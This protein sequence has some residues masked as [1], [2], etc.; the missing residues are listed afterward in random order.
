MIT[1]YV[2]SDKNYILN[3]IKYFVTKMTSLVSVCLGAKN[4]KPCNIFKDNEKDRVNIEFLYNYVKDISTTLK[5]ASEIIEE[6]KLYIIAMAIKYNKVDVLKAFYDINYI[7]KFELL[8]ADNI[9]YDEG[10]REMFTESE[11]TYVR[12]DKDILLTRH[13]DDHIME[14]N[15]DALTL[16][17]IFE[18]YDVIDYLVDELK[19]YGKVSEDETY[20][21]CPILSM[22]INYKVETSNKNYTNVIEYIVKKCD[23]DNKLWSKIFK[24]QVIIFPIYNYPKYH[25]IK[26][27]IPNKYAVD[28]EFQTTQEIYQGTPQYHTCFV[29]KMIFEQVLKKYCLTNDINKELSIEDIY[30][31]FADTCDIFKHKENYLA[32]KIEHVHR[33]L[34]DFKEFFYPDGLDSS[35]FVEH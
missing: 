26:G 22:I 10:H 31:A 33:I 18:S 13:I 23:I 28:A 4:F 9:T 1:V 27:E 8:S 30:N 25:K 5:E 14:A 32:A 2:N 6:C 3:C 35:I 11:E 17:S 7:E 24:E 34:K 12:Y 21:N 15:I 20:I 16:A 29:R 19:Y